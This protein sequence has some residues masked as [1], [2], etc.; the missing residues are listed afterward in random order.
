MLR[1]V[2]WR[3]SRP[4]VVETFTQLTS[5]CQASTSGSGSPASLAARVSCMLE[6]MYIHIGF[7]RFSS[8][9]YKYVQN[10][11]CQDDICSKCV[12]I[13]FFTPAKYDAQSRCRSI[14]R[15]ILKNK[16][17]FWDMHYLALQSFLKIV[18]FQ[19]KHT[20]PAHSK[21]VWVLQWSFACHVVKYLC[22]SYPTNLTSAATCWFAQSGHDFRARAIL[23]F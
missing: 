1:F 7:Q 11:R 13:F 19:S 5:N 2:F 15:S 14:I 3:C 10:A 12:H 21:K 22:Q 17:V 20:A 16:T 4:G 6:K 9:T 18:V 23:D 8:W